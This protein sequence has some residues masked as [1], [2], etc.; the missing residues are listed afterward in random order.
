[1]ELRK[2]LKVDSISR[3]G[4]TPPRPIEA[5]GPVSAAVEQMR[6]H[7]TGCLVVVRHGKLVGIFTERDL[8]TR[9]LAAGLPLSVPVSEVMTSNPV[10]VDP[11]DSVRVAI[12]RMQQGGYRHLPVVNGD[13]KPTGIVSAKRIVNY[14]AEH[15]PSTVFA[16]PDPNDVPASAEGA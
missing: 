4:P 8:L 10:T 1:M 7:K 9:V 6:L 13:G 11:K 16:L 3:L 15:Y 2:N 14:L 5:E 12:E